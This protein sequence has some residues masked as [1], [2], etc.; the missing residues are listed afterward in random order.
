MY[1]C[2]W[3]GDVFVWSW[4]QGSADHKMSIEVFS[5]QFSLEE[6]KKDRY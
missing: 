5:L 1:V 4:Y 6:F 3:K 2:I